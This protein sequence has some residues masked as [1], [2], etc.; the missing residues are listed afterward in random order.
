MLGAVS[1]MLARSPRAA[2]RQSAVEPGDLSA[3]DKSL[4]E[5]KARFNPSLMVNAPGKERDG[6]SR[7]KST[8]LAPDDEGR[9]KSMG[10]EGGREGRSRTISVAD[11]APPRQMRHSTSSLAAPPNSG[12][13]F[14]RV[15]LETQRKA[16]KDEVKRK[17]R[18]L[19]TLSKCQKMAAEVHGLFT[20][21]IYIYIHIS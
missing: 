4:E 18:L 10:R 9:G 7:G 20:I 21:R 3:K 17:R 19:E 11:D 13:A 16:R 2:D 8:R 5:L 6:L 15:V 1:K 14:S 12:A